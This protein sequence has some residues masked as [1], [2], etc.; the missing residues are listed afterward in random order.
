MIDG[1]IYF[2]R[3]KDEILQR[4]NDMEKGRIISKMLKSNE[5]GEQSKPYIK[6]GKRHFHCNTLGEEGTDEENLH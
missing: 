4:R 3:K 2:E 6:K 5:S 1:S